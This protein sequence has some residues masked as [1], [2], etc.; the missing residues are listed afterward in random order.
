MNSEQYLKYGRTQLIFDLRIISY[1]T[2]KES[3]LRY[4]YEQE[5]KE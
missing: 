2:A 5:K 1:D 3:A 4:V